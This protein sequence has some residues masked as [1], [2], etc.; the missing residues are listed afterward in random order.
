MLWIHPFLGPWSPLYS[1]ANG[2]KVEMMTGAGFYG[3]DWEV[4][5]VT[6]AYFTG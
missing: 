5:H 3:P 6:S 1:A 4:V 2:E